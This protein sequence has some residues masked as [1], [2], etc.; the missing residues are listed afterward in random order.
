MIIFGIDPSFRQSGFSICEINTMTSPPVVSFFEFKKL[1]DFIYWFMLHR[2][3]YCFAVIENSNLQN[4]TFLSSI[5]KGIQNKLSRDAGKNQAIS[6]MVL[7]LFQDKYSADNVMNISPKSK[8]QKWA[9]NKV[10][11]SYINA[12]G[13]ELADKKA[14]TK[15]NQ[16]KR[17]ALKLAIIGYNY[18][19]LKNK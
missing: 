10:A 13:L 8:G 14:L 12:L 18:L 3:D 17:D 6:Q 1:T 15:N 7:D 9:S 11:I 4:T 2:P 5:N 16:D 19:N